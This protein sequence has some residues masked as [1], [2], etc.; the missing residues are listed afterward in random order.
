MA[1]WAH[2]VQAHSL[3][4]LNNR[5]RASHFCSSFNLRMLAVVCPK[6]PYRFEMPTMQIPQPPDFTTELSSPGP[7]RDAYRKQQDTLLQQS[8]ISTAID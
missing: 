8:L 5:V 1:Y 3:T 2:F 6:V 7:L 4:N